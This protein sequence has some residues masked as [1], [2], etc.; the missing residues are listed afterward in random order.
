MADATQGITHQ[1]QRLAEEIGEAGV[2]LIILLNK[3][4]AADPEAKEDVED[5]TGDRLG[6][7]AWAPVLRVL[8]AAAAPAST[9]CRK[10]CGPCWRPA[11]TGCPPPS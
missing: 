5:G 11:A 4:D 9:A 8:R 7:V 10:R 3:W 2:G 6:F 1:E